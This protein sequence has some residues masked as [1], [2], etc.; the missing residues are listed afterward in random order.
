M[1]HV[2]GIYQI[3][4]PSKH[5]R[6]VLTHQDLWTSNIMFHQPTQSSSSTHAKLIDFQCMRY[7]P[8]SADVML[9][10]HLTTRR[11]HRETNFPEYLK[12]YY[13]HLSRQ[14]FGYGLDATNL[15]R[16]EDLQ[17]SCK[18]L[19][20]LALVNACTLL[21]WIRM[22]DNSVHQLKANDYEAYERIAYVRRIDYI[23]EQM[24]KDR[25]YQEIVEEVVCELVEW[26]YE[27]ETYS[28][29]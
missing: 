11:S 13:A 23:V 29:E 10:L 18:T 27:Q 3:I 15:I 24:R 5:H 14:L 4:Q 6:N 26:V 28:K 25:Q 2:D 9:L 19:R 12:F 20:F 16:F 7:L 22:P 17:A 8:P 21:P 1:K